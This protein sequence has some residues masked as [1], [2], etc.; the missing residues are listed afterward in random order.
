VQQL[1]K[2]FSQKIGMMPVR[3]KFQ[4][5]EMDLPLRAALRNY[6][7]SKILAVEKNTGMYYLSYK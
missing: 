1:S 7:D 6:V 2:T 4:V 3:D 5:D